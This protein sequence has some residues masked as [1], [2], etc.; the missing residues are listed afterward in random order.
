MWKGEH[1]YYL[2]AKGRLVLPAAFRNGRSGGP[3]DQLILTRGFEHCAMAFSP[4]EWASREAK[5]RTLPM[6]DP[7]AR[8]L[9]RF[10]VGPATECALDKQ[11]RLTI[12]EP[13]REHA[14]IQRE[15]V[16]SGMGAY[17][18]IWAKDRW[19]RIA[20]EAEHAVQV[21]AKRFDL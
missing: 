10:L 15:V 21:T 12:P 20:G 11:G 18:E 16:I 6:T 7:D 2:D 8:A 14:G 17:L 9:L 5:L 1:C 19:D 4:E 3:L 13:L